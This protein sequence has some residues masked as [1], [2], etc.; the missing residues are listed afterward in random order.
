MPAS[1]AATSASMMWRAHITTGRDHRPVPDAPGGVRQN[2]FRNRGVEAR[3]DQ[4]LG[5][6]RIPRANLV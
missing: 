1:D 3:P 6:V 4:P 2:A 5:N